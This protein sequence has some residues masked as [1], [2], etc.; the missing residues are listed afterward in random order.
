MT[1]L[2]D[3]RRFEQARVAGEEERLGVAVA[4]RLEFLEPSGEHRR[5]A[6]E[7]QLG[8]NAQKALGLA[9]G[10]V[11]LGIS[12]QAALQ[13]GK[14]FRG[15]REAHGEGVA[16]EAGEEVG[17]GFDG[18]EQRESVDGAAGAVGMPSG[19]SSMLMTMAGLAVRSTTREARMPMTPRCQP[20]PSMTRRRS[21][22]ISESAARRASMV[23][24]AA[25]ST[26]RRSRLSRSNLLASSV[27]AVRVAR[28]EKLDDF[29]GDVHAAGGVDAR[30]EA[31]GDVEAGELLGRGIER[32]RGK[33]RAE[34]GAHGPA[35]L[36]QSNC[37]DGAI[38]AAQRNRVGDGGDGCHFEEAGQ[39]F[40]ARP[41]RLAAFEQR[42]RQLERDGRAAKDFLRIRA[43]RLIRVEDGEGSGERVAGG[44]QVMVGDDQIQT[45]P[46][47]GF[48]FGKGA[49]AGVDG[50]H[51][52]NAVGVRSFKHARL[53]AVA[54]AE[55]VRHVET[56]FTAEHLDGGLEQDH[57]DSA[58]HIVVAV[59]KNGLARG[60]GA[61]EPLDGRGHAE[62]EKGIM[63]MRGLGI[64]EGEG[65]GGLGDAA[66]DEQ[67]GENQRQAGFAGESG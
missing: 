51:D 57:G 61:F 17:A 64:E 24:S 50:D 54:F 2:H 62:H 31:K 15:K 28:G 66:G 58:V 59:K 18:G 56:C 44:R 12:A 49:H 25:A 67:L 35:Q 14:F 26:S 30:R 47:R 7:R 27:G 19:P 32:G 6:V 41:L 29:R 63:E 16:A 11:L 55:A 21:A 37:R 65:L 5:D 13:F 46:P 33:E 39:G 34:T 4:E 52:A 40:F 48:R 9:R 45:Q 38:F 43:S 20:S 53:H 22:A 60:D 23:V 8:V 1:S 10:E 42:L 36:L 3:A